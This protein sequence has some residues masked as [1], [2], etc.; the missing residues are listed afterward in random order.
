[1]LSLNGTPIGNT[2]KR[3]IVV[4]CG[5]VEIARYDNLHPV[6]KSLDA[7]ITQAISNPIA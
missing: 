1:M 7:I 2:G 5:N 3:M 4:D 6:P